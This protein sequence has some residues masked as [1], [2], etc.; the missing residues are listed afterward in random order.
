MTKLEQ[1]A[2][3]I[4]KAEH[5][6]DAMWANH[7]GAARAAVEEARNV[8][9]AMREAGYTGSGEDSYGVAVGAWEAMCDAI[10]SEPQP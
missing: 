1:I 7:M 2:R 10:L 4:A 3:A 9:E 6:T 8:N 5:G